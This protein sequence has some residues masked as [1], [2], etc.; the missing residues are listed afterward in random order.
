MAMLSLLDKAANVR[1]AHAEAKDAIEKVREAG[2]EWHLLYRMT[3]ESM[4]VAEDGMR[5]AWNALDSIKR[6]A[7]KVHPPQDERGEVGK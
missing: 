3:E 7:E 6:L 1:Q 2:G 5:N 4:G